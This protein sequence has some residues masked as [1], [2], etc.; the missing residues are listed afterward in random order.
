MKKCVF[1]LVCVFGFV[2][3]QSCEG[4]SGPRGPQGPQGVPGVES[5]VFEVTTSFTNANNYSANFVLNPPILASDNVL[6]YELREVINGQDVWK[7]L[8]QTYFFDFGGGG[9][10]TYNYDFTKND[11][12][13]FLDATFDLN[14]LDSSWK[15]NITF[16]IV[17]VPGYF[18][19]D[20]I[21]TSDINAVM[22]VFNIDDK[23]VITLEE[24]PY[25]F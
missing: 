4:P 3:L 23:S 11:F 15:N 21:D 2:F 10:M 7:L 8:P 9:I 13:L 20:G 5:E 16:R 22:E 24:S 19:L 25:R 1:I 12:R 6:V 14:F 17:I 18:S